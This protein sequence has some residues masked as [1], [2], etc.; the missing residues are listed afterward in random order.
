MA[1]P[2]QPDKYYYAVG[3]NLVC[4]STV[5]PTAQRLLNGHDDDVTALAVSVCGAAFCR[6]LPSHPAPL[7]T[8]ARTVPFVPVLQRLLM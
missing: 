2:S 6:L 1:H 3:T 4:A 7:A 8:D 5:D